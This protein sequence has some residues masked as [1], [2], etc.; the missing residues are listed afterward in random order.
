MKFTALWVFTLL[1]LLSSRPAF[2]AEAIALDAWHCAPLPPEPGGAT[3]QC[4]AVFNLA[5][6]PHSADLAARHLK[7]PRFTAPAAG[8]ALYVEEIPEAD[9]VFVNEVE[10]GAT[11]LGGGGEAHEF[12]TGYRRAYP[13]PD[14]ALRAG[15]NRMTLF[16][17]CRGRRCQPAPAVVTSLRQAWRWQWEDTI[18]NLVLAASLLLAASFF[19]LVGWAGGRELRYLWFAFFITVGAVEILVHEPAWAADGWRTLLFRMESVSGLLLLPLFMRFLIAAK[20]LDYRLARRALLHA[21]RV[22]PLGVIF[23]PPEKIQTAALAINGANAA[24]LALLLYEMYIREARPGPDE[25]RSLLA[26]SLLLFAGAAG[27]FLL[28]RQWIVSPFGWL[29]SF[30]P[31]AMV[32]SALIA[33]RSLAARYRWLQAAAYHDPLTAL[34]TRRMASEILPAEL[35]RAGRLNLPVTVL[36]VDID[37]FK[38]VNDQHGHA[39]GDAV[40]RE[41]GERLNQL[42]REGDLLCR[43]GG[44]EFALFLLGQDEN[45]GAAFAE[46]LRAAVAETPFAIGANRTTPVTISIGVAS[47]SPAAGMEKLIAAADAALYVAKG[48]GR[49]RVARYG[50]AM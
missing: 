17:W 32:A 6:A 48:Q 12:A 39:A 7:Q 36:F 4:D 49:N 30:M 34:G 33:A 50:A 10:V 15:E 41:L 45:S 16:A 35:S 5:A 1:A 38:K 2:A 19:L 47:L 9:A 22:L 46:R 27:D 14:T 20:D 21:L 18:V 11:G 29:D 44:E 8:Y 3:M 26:A 31:I 37:H 43:W 28:S 24:L 25:R 40:L 13:I 23:I 42:R